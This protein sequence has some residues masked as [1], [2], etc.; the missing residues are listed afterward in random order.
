MKV[1]AAMHLRH[2]LVAC[3]ASE[4]SANACPHAA[5]L[6][7]IFQ[8]RV[9]LVFMDTAE[10]GP[11]VETEAAR[12]YLARY[13]DL[14]RLRLEQNATLLRAIK[15]SVERVELVGDPAGAL[16][17]WADENAV[18]LMVLIRHA[19][20]ADNRAVGS[21]TRAVLRKAKVPSWCSMTSPRRPQTEWGIAAS[22]TART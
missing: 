12:G 2:I 21:T 8:A 17:H 3:D 7:D 5:A 22:S 6:A 18:D 4:T 15:A 10:T 19:A 9:G 14:V 16:L 13:Y 1:A 11:Y 20:R